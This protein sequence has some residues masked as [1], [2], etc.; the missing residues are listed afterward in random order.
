M[1]TYSVDRIYIIY[2]VSNTKEFKSK[3]Y[4]LKQEIKQINTQL[5]NLINITYVQI[6]KRNFFNAYKKIIQ[7]YLQERNNNIITN[8]TAGHKIISYIMSTAHSVVRSIFGNTNSHILYDQK[9]LNDKQLIPTVLFDFKQNILEYILDLYYVNQKTIEYEKE[10]KRYKFEI[11]EYGSEI[12]KTVKY[13]VVNSTKL[14]LKKGYSKKMYSRPTITRYNKKLQKLGILDNAY[15][16]TLFG[17]CIGYI[18]LLI[19]YN[20][21]FN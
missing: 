17:K 6:D 9:N 2:N 14:I 18:S 15:N 10:D 12:P 1:Y 8:I 7:L 20:A 11:D 13:N 5:N 19:P 3:I 16:F 4:D 21:I